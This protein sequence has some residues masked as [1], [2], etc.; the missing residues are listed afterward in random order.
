[1]KSGNTLW[2]FGNIDIDCSR[3][4][5]MGIVNVTPDSFSDGGRF[6]DPESAIS[7]AKNLSERKA[8]ILDI[9]GESTR[10]GSDPVD[11]DE[12]LRRVIPVIEGIRRLGIET[13]ISIDTRRLSVA[14]KAVDAGAT[15]INDVTA[16]RDRPELA[17]FIAERN[18]GVVLM[19][20]LGR[21]K[22]MQKDPHYDDVISEI[23]DFFEERL[24]FA[25]EKRIPAENIVLDPG[26]GFGKKLV[27]NLTILRECG[28]WLKYNRPI[29]IGPSRKRFIG[30]IIDR[31]VTERL[32]GTI[33]ACVAALH[34]GA[35]IF[36]VHDA[37]PVRDALAIAYSI[38]EGA[39]DN[40][41]D[42]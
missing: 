21:P 39:R 14:E 10:P 34:S 38:I 8:D 27:H 17:D 2:K 22:T 15:I 29:L 12:E 30:G 4:I 20:M 36:R 6:F 41:I 5:I 18:L 26:I 23:G 9:G 40:Q 42:G 16:L 11:E 35:R 13:P 31:D 19:H 25:V 24:A 32:Y 7:Q 33:G 1:M 28:T 37:G 3:P